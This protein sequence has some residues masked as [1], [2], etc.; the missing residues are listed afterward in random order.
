MCRRGSVRISLG[1]MWHEDDLYTWSSGLVSCS[2]TEVS[3]KDASHASL[4][5]RRLPEVI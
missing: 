5:Q 2:R 3:L 4:A 1:I